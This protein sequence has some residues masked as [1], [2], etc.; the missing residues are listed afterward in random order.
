MTDDER[1]VIS[2]FR[3]LLDDS[4]ESVVMTDQDIADLWG[5]HSAVCFAS[6]LIT[7]GLTVDRAR[8]MVQGWC[9]REKHAR[10]QAGER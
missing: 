1:E 9:A 7:D 5:A 6:W 8:G 10:W 2:L 3:S 4:V